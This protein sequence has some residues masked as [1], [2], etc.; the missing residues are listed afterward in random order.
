[1]ATKITKTQAAALAGL[2]HD[3][4]TTAPANWGAT[5]WYIS[6]GRGFTQSVSKATLLTLAKLGY[7]SNIGPHPIEWQITEAGRA[8]L[9]AYDASGVGK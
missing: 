4:N 7:I 3:V 9:A 2:A 8:A 6:N 1:M 5:G